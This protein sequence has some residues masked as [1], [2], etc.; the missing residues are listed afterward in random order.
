MFTPS[1]VE[2]VSAS[3]GD[4]ALEQARHARPKL[5]DARAQRL[6]ERLAGTALA[7]LA[8]ERGPSGLERLRRDRAVRS[9][10]QVDQPLE[11]R[12]LASQLVHAAGY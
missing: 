2:P 5:V 7:S 6:E 4:I 8:L 9:R 12:E 11:H 10:V 3:L 1:V